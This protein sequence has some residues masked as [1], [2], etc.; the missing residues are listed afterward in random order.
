MYTVKRWLCVSVSCV[1][2]SFRKAERKCFFKEASKSH[3]RDF[4]EGENNSPGPVQK[5]LVLFDYTICPRNLSSNT[6][7]TVQ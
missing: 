4:S 2:V 6:A 1:G 7:T 3:H 5:S